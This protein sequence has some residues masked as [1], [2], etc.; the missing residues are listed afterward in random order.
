[1]SNRIRSTILG[2]VAM[3]GLLAAGQAKADRVSV[4]LGLT[5]GYG[6]F[7][8]LGVNTGGRHG[9][10]PGY[11]GGMYMAPRAVVV[12]PAPVVYQRPIIYAQPSPVVYAPAPVVYA[13]P[14]PVVYATTPAPVVYAPAPVVVQNEGYWVENDN[15]VWVA[16]V[17]VDVTDAWGR[18]IRQ[19]QPGHWEQRHTREWRQ[20][21]R[22][23]GDRQGPQQGFG[24]GDHDG[25]GHR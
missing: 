16:G 13:Q 6:D 22:G 21:N 1:M 15:N 18:R 25:H 12:A 3:T 7:F 20:P 17:Y 8:S 24:G 11:V 19:Q 10:A 5:D 4:G 2:M 23:G 14:A 9:Y